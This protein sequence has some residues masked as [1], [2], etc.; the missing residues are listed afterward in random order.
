LPRRTTDVTRSRSKITLQGTT[1]QI[2]YSELET[3]MPM[4][5]QEVDDFLDVPRLAHF[6]TIGPGGAPWVRPVWYI[7]EKRAFY[8]TTRRWARRTGVDIESG[9]PM[10][11]SIASEAH[12]YQAVLARG[13]AEVWATDRDA[14]LQRMSRRYG[15]FPAWYEGALN[16]NDRVILRLEPIH[17]VAWDFG[18]GD[19]EELNAGRSLRMKA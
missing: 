8:F 14:W 4:T 1:G 7:W 6:A 10:A 12:P 2:G 9:A 11:V 17:L 16:E 13:T 15:T 19:Y 5:M 3:A 18:R